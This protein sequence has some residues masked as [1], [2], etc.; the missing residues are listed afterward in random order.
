MK[1]CSCGRSLANHNRSGTCTTCTRTP[2][3]QAL[4]DAAREM[5]AEIG[6]CEVLGNVHTN[7][8][9]THR[10][11]CASCALRTALGDR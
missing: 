5:L 2:K 11:P 3:S 6:A 4:R 7:G 8:S 10:A 1:T 9:G